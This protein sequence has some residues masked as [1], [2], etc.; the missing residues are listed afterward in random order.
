VRG[1]R[2]CER[3]SVCENHYFNPSAKW[4]SVYN[5]SQMVW[6]TVR[7][8]LGLG[9]AVSPLFR[10]DR[11]PVLPFPARPL[12]PCS[13]WRVAVTSMPRVDKPRDFPTQLLH[14]CKAVG[15]GAQSR[16]WAVG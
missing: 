14:R 2:R 9:P 15:C 3:I 16:L 6:R 10:I 1:V 11:G 5:S 4:N 12:I 8:K 7:E 13:V